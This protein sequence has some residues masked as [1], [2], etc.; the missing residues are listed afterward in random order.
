MTG[1]SSDWRLVRLVAAIEFSTHGLLRVPEFTNRKRYGAIASHASHHTSGTSP[2]CAGL[3]RGRKDSGRYPRPGSGVCGRLSGEMRWFYYYGP[4][5]LPNPGQIEPIIWHQHD[6]RHGEMHPMPKFTL[7]P[8]EKVLDCDSGWVRVNARSKGLRALMKGK[9]MSFEQIKAVL[10]GH[11]TEFTFLPTFEQDAAKRAQSICQ[12]ALG[13]A[14]MAEENFDRSLLTACY[15]DAFKSES[16]WTKEWTERPIRM[17]LF[18][19][20]D[21]SGPEVMSLPSTTG[22]RWQKI[23]VTH[24]QGRLDFKGQVIHKFDQFRI[25]GPVFEGDRDDAE[26]DLLN[27]V[28]AFNH[29]CNIGDGRGS[30]PDHKRLNSLVGDGSDF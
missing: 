21:W 25:L 30:R 26:L 10:T 6:L 15:W 28:R 11:D 20:S 3:T 24:D 7:L 13:Y 17:R 12:E 4:R 16:E 8:I 18:T 1:R 9:R 14:C 2:S 22:P 5:H 27:L 23:L 29:L 19:G